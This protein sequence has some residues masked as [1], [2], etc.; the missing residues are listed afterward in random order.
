MLPCWASPITLSIGRDGLT[1]E[2]QGYGYP[3]GF[4]QGY[5]GVW[6]RVWFPVPKTHRG[7]P[8]G[9]AIPMGIIIP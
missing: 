6:V 2:R 9:M 3:W 5:A 4:F 7:I 8:Q 1:S